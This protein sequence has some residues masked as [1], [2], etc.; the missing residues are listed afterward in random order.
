MNP[1]AK[2]VRK[3]G[4]LLRRDRFRA[5]LD[6]EMAFHREQGEKELIAEGMPAASART[7]ASRQ[8]GNSAHLRDASQRVVAFQWETI[9]R[10]LR[11]ALRQ[12]RQHL[13]FALTAVFILAVG[14]GVSVAIFA[15]ADA[16]LIQPLPYLA[17]DRLMDVAENGAML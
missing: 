13:G 1:L 9:W 10:G 8:V 11:F 12:F 17:P 14:M 6:E 7:A 4:M 16:A 5:D 2:I 15:F 3:F